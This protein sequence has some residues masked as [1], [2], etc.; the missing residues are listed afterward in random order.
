[1]VD[2]HPRPGIAHD[3]P[4]FLAH[5]F[6][7]AVDGTVGAD[8]L[9]LAELA[10][11]RPL[12]GIGEEF[13]AFRAEFFIGRSVVVAAIKPDHCFDSPFFSFCAGGLSHV[14]LPTFFFLFE[15]TI[16]FYEVTYFAIL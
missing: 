6:F 3:G 12:L 9:V 16:F 13:L 4:D 1:M 14:Y 2:D 10:V 7:V 15:F 5:V 8:G 11:F